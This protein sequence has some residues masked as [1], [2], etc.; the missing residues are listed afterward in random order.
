MTGVENAA[1]AT[2]R[3]PATRDR[4]RVTATGDTIGGQA[5]Y[6]TRIYGHCAPPAAPRRPVIGGGE[7]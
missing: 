5:L 2:V 1:S 7:D 6:R 4:T 3:L